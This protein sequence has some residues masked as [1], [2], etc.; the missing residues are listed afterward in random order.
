MF[1]D[2][3]QKLSADVCFYVQ[4]VG[5]IKPSYVCL[6]VFIM[7][8]FPKY[9]I[10]ALSKY[11][12]FGRQNVLGHLK[13]LLLNNIIINILRGGKQISLDFGFNEREVVHLGSIEPVYKKIVCCRYQTLGAVPQ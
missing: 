11:R 7:S 13:S 3:V 9:K 2:G 5:R 6:S 4:A 8:D 1:T 12:Q 10:W